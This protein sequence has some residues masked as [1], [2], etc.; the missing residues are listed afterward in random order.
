MEKYHL[1]FHTLHLKRWDRTIYQQTIKL[2]YFKNKV[3]GKIT[4]L[5]NDYTYIYIYR[6]LQNNCRPLQGVIPEYI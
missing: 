1:N 4:Q 3:N 5:I 2:S 6:V